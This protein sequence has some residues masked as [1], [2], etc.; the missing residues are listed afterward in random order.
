MPCGCKVY[1]PVDSTDHDE[2]LKKRDELREYLNA[3]H[4]PEPKILA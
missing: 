1:M 3:Q 2:Q 4:T